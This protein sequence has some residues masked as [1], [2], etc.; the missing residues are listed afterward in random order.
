MIA[1]CIF[2]FIRQI[3]STIIETQR[4]IN[5]AKTAMSTDLYY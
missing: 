4:N 5:I 1:L 2:I 3:D